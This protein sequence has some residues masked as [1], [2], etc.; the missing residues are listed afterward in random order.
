MSSPVPESGGGP[1]APPLGPGPTP[2]PVAPSGWVASLPGVPNPSG[3]RLWVRQAMWH[4]TCTHADWVVALLNWV[5]SARDLFYL[6]EQTPDLQHVM[7][8]APGAPGARWR[9][10]GGR[11]TKM[12]KGWAPQPAL[13]ET[14]TLARI[15]APSLIRAFFRREPGAARSP[16]APAERPRPQRH[17]DR[18]HVVAVA[19][20][21]QELRR[22]A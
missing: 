21:H 14:P 22:L 7:T 4:E 10:H 16:H 6:N 2:G 12:K 13:P 5:D 3:A 8:G 9:G 1:A 11:G 17:R 15:R 18:R 20:R 19:R